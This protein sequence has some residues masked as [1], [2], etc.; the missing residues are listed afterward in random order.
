MKSTV[1]GR[2]KRVAAP[3]LAIEIALQSPLWNRCRSVRTVLHRALRAAAAAT[4]LS[5]GE[6]SI[7][8][9][10]DKAMRRLNRDWRRKDMPTNVLAFPIDIMNA[11]PGRPR[12]LGDIVI[13]YQTLQ[14]E[15]R[16]Q[17]KPVAQH[18]A[19]VAVHG[20]LHL[21][22]YDHRTADEAQVMERL[23]TS[24]LARLDIPDPYIE[25][26]RSAAI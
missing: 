3:S 4:S 21:M 7:V 16:M 17:G 5:G 18:L 15:A 24:I 26:D 13:S 12:L 8:L 22:G 19:H 6:I 23:E 1:L 2:R 14:R 9:C 20:L 11:A 10:D 25:R